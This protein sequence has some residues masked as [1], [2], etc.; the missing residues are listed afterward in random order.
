MLDVRAD[1][2]CSRCH[3]SGVIVEDEEFE[4][5]IMAFMV[6]CPCMRMDGLDIKTKKYVSSIIHELDRLMMMKEKML[7]DP[8]K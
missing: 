3:G 4:G 2:F 7:C 6:D 8:L 5:Q 1:P